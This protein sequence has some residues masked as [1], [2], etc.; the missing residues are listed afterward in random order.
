MTLLTA[1]LFQSAF[2][3]LDHFL[4]KKNFINECKE[5]SVLHLGENLSNHEMIYLKLNCKNVDIVENEI[6]SEAN[7]SNKVNWNKATPNQI[8]SFKEEFRAVLSDIPVPQL[9]LCCRDVHCTEEN[10]RSQLDIYAI[11]VLTALEESVQ[12]NIPTVKSC[13]KRSVVPGWTEYVKPVREDM[14]FWRAIWVSLGRPQ[15]TEVHRIYRHLRHQYAYSIRRVKAQEQEMR[16]RKLISDAV[17]GKINDIVKTVKR[18]RTPKREVPNQMDDISGSQEISDHFSDIYKLIYNK[19]EENNLNQVREEVN[20]NVSNS[21]LVWA[22]KI[23][24]ELVHKLIGKLSVGKNDEIFDFKS[25]AIKLTADVISEPLARLFKAFLVHGHLTNTFLFCSLIPLIKDATKSKI[26]SSNYRLIAISSLI[27]KLMDL[28]ILDLFSSEL[29]VSSLQFGFLR[30]SSTTLCS[31][32]LCESINYFTNR[33]TPVYLCL[34]DLTKA[35]DHVKLDLLFDKLK[36]RIPG[37]FVRF[38][39][40]TYMNQQCYV[41][42]GDSKSRTF[43][44]S[45]GVR[46]GAVASPILFNLYMDELFKILKDSKIGCTI[47]NLYYGILGYADDCTLTCPTRSG[48]QKLIDLVALYCDKHGITISTNQDLAKSK[49]KCII[50]NSD[51][52]A[53]NIK[54]YGVPLP[55]VDHW[56]HLGHIIHRDESPSHDTL[57]KRAEFIGKIHALHQ[58]MGKIDPKVFLILV[59]IYLSSFYGSNIWDLTSASAGRLYATWNNMIRTAFNLPYATHRYILKEISELRPLQETLFK[60]FAKFCSQILNSGKPEVVHLF[61]KQKYDSRS[62]FGKNYKSYM[63]YKTDF[64]TNYRVPPNGEQRLAIVRQLLN[65]RDH[66][67]DVGNF[68]AEAL[69][70]FLR[71]ACCT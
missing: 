71:E 41:K 19:H 36:A 11:S 2:S 59:R 48:L 23:T 53:V 17:Q 57:H 13:K 8:S 32:T 15:N 10:H 26:Q 66:N 28:V 22:D 67:V 5:A 43:G 20:N 52:P 46:Q 51:F 58:E 27:L 40:Y 38:I 45:N 63:V 34:L 61:H 30:G 9:A 37:I 69:T 55:Y 33:G 16:N 29:K 21:D 60:R 6:K 44:I 3:T 49:T 56:K 47:D 4:V 24:P 12:H 68:P 42:W 35:F 14:N 62:V 31:W 1:I 50:F 25:D 64:L 70:L 7:P 65:I 39:I 54:L 18:Q